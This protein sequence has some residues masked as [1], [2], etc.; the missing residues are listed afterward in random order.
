[1]VTVL[2]LR[3]A[4]G[5]RADERLCE[6]VQPSAG[7][8]R[9]TQASLRLSEMQRGTLEGRPD[10]VEYSARGARDSDYYVEVSV[11]IAAPPSGAALRRQAQRVLDGI[12]FP[13]W[14]DGCRS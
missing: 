13:R 2:L 8:P 1:M 14:G 9:L 11:D 6:G 3:R 10:V 5:G 12:A 7:Y 4:P